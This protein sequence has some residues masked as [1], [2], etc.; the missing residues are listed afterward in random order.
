MPTWL[1]DGI[2]GLTEME[3][4]PYALAGPSPIA[5]F[6]LA[7]PLKADANAP[8]KILWVVGTPR[9][10]G[11]LEIRVHPTGAA[12]PALTAS[13]PADSGPTIYP[14]GVQVPTAGCWHFSL[15][16]A[17]GHADLDLLYSP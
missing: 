2:Q 3:D 1:H 4:A 12:E 15:Q 11:S 8:A 14:D 16:W 10:H 7:Y 13:R 5:G 6:L 9:N 17:T